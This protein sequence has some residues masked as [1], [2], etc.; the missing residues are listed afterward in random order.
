MA[1]TQAMLSYDVTQTARVAWFIGQY[2]AGARV[3]RDVLRTIEWPNDLPDRQIILRDMRALFERDRENIRRGYYKAPHDMLV[4]PLSVLGQAREFFRDLNEV[5]RR[6]LSGAHQEAK[7]DVPDDPNLPRYFKQNF[8]FQTGGYLTEESA[9]LYDYQV[10]VLFAGSADAMRRQAL[11]PLHQFLQGRDPAETRLLDVA[12]GTGKFLT[13]V[14]DNYPQMP[15][16]GCDLSAPYLAKAR[17]RTRPF[18]PVAFKQGAAEKLPYPDASV[19]V[20]TDIY[21]FHELPRKIRAQAAAEFAR[22]LR[23]GGRLI[24]IDTIQFGDF[25]PFDALIESF[26]RSHHEPYYLDYARQDL[27]ELFGAA[28]LIKIGENRAHLSKVTVFQAPGGRA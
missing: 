24:H 8:H 13:F 11:V 10:E 1:T 6:R 25:S 17:E 16:A 14:Q 28:G 27:T 21:L 19:D 5:N 18:G 23:P 2:L 4:N 9:E 22:V 3:S 20:L 26:P 7:S 15:V 12:C